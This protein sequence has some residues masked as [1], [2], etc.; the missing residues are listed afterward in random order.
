[1]G[2][3]GGSGNAVG[4]IVQGGCEG[5]GGVGPSLMKLLSEGAGEGEGG[6]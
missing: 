3:M 2:E 4:I 5:R 6:E 1:M